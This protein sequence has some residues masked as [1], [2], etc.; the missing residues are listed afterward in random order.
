MKVLFVASANKG[1]IGP[2]VKAQGN[3][4]AKR[5]VTVEYYGI[6]VRGLKGYLS[7][8]PGLRKTIKQTNPDI[9]HAH[10]SFCGFVAALTLTNK[11]IVVS[12]MGSDIQAGAFFR[13]A[14]RFFYHRIW[15]AVIVKSPKMKSTLNLSKAHITPNG[16]DLSRFMEMDST[17]LKKKFGFDL[18]KKTILFL[19]DPSRH[20]KNYALAVKAFEYI[21]QN[22]CKFKVRYNLSH[23]EVPEVINAAGVILLTSKWEGSPNVVKEAMACNRPVVA[24]NVG[25]IEWLFGNEPGHFLTTFDPQDVASKIENALKFSTEHQRTNGRKRIEELGLDTD[26]VAKKVIDVYRTISE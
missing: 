19:A 23:M 5:G 24:T 13:N 18:N 20:E 1:K 3:S 16:V 7:N 12:L 17:D 15:D 4:L 26:N 14:I 22:N 10:Y 11:P 25:D 9:I 8:I 2:L 6:K 21:K